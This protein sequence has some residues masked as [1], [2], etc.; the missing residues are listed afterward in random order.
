MSKF[1]T[2]A[3]QL[4]INATA[5]Q[6]LTLISNADGTFTIAR[7]NIGATTDDIITIDA[8]GGVTLPNNNFTSAEQT[9]SAAGILAIP[10]GLGATPFFVQASI[11]CK[12]AEL[13]YSIGD[14]TLINSSVTDVLGPTGISI[15]KTTT[16]IDVTFGNNA[17]PIHIINKGTGAAAAITAANWKLVLRAMK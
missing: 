6:N 10:H 13:G 14:E 9:I 15:S 5:S 17:F 4:G 16:N 2:G 1:K 11:V 8:N 12:I 3:I 7:G